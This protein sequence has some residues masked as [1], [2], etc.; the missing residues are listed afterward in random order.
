MLAPTCVCKLTGACAPLPFPTLPDLL[1]SL[2]SQ[3]DLTQAEVQSAFSGG[4]ASTAA[5]RLSEVQA[6]CEA[7]SDKAGE[8]RRQLEA[9]QAGAEDVA[10]VRAGYE[11]QLVRLQTLLE[12]A[13][14]SS[15]ARM[16]QQV[17]GRGE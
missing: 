11:A 13:N 7:Y 14:T 12:G 5:A 1:L 3:L 10:G 6:A 8:L 4:H 2:R 9:A 17:G 16:M 15:E